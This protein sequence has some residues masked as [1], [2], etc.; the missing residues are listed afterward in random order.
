M[1]LVRR[2]SVDEVELNFLP[3]DIKAVKQALTAYLAV[4]NHAELVFGREIEEH[5][6]LLEDLVDDLEKA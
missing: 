2:I 1:A 4:I 6:Q 5:R 3:H